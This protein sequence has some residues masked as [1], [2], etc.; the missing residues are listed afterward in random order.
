[1]GGGFEL[2]ERG[3]D[4]TGAGF[5]E[6]GVGAGEV[7]SL[8]LEDHAD[9]ADDYVD[10]GALGGGGGGGGEERLLDG[11]EGADVALDDVEVWVL[12]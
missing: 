3:E 2:S 5:A 1:M 8:S 11:V 12:G 9:C 6:G 7:D 10:E 4:A